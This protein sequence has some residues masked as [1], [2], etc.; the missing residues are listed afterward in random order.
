M[1]QTLQKTKKIRI[2]KGTYHCLE[3]RAKEKG[4]TAN[5]Y[6]NQLLEEQEAAHYKPT[7][8]AEDLKNPKVEWAVP[9]N[10]FA[11]ATMISDAH[12]KRLRRWLDK[13]KHLELSTGSKNELIIQNVEI[14]ERE[15]LKEALKKQKALDVKQ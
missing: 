4:L 1:E 12:F 7:T 9:K 15:R 10:C 2:G 6:A 14:L 5:E 13:K 3:V 11:L 8:L